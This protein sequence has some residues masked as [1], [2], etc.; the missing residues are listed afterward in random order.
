MLGRDEMGGGLVAPVGVAEEEGPGK[1]AEEGV[2]G[3]MCDETPEEEAS[4]NVRVRVGRAPGVVDV[5]EERSR[6][7]VEAERGVEWL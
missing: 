7:E 2:V 1:C 4:E 5:E 6:F 3:P